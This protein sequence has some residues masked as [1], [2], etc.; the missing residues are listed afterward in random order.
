M[1]E[2]GPSFCMPGCCLY[3]AR[4]PQTLRQNHLIREFDFVTFCANWWAL[5]P[6][7]LFEAKPSI[8]RIFFGS[9]SHN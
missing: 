8:V 9:N 7:S 1:A 6:I 5:S 3:N 2:L 4:Q